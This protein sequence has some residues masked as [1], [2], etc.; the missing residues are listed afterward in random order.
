MGIGGISVWQ[1]LIILAIVIMLFGTKRDERTVIDN[2]EPWY[3]VD[4]ANPPNF[5]NVKVLNPNG[6]SNSFG[7]TTAGTGA[8]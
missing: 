1:L 5:A 4:M 8:V 7:F 6:D 3:S 2:N